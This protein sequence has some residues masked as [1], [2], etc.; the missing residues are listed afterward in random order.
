MLVWFEFEE[1]W[2]FTACHCEI[3]V[4][5]WK[6][7]SFFREG[8]EI[9]WDAT[10]SVNFTSSLNE[11]VTGVMN[12]AGKFWQVFEGRALLRFITSLSFDGIN[13]IH[14]YKSNTKCWPPWC[15]CHQNKKK[16][17]DL[18]GQYAPMI[19]LMHRKLPKGSIPWIDNTNLIW[20]EVNVRGYGTPEGVKCL[21]LRANE[22]CKPMVV[23]CDWGTKMPTG[24]E[25]HVEYVYMF[26][27]RTVNM[28]VAL[29][30]GLWN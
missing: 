23:M 14:P 9:Y 12:R 4:E 13:D 20:L 26:A 18:H 24:A 1:L 28:A 2:L 17:R 15:W 19:Y 8:L 21:M 6:C 22:M 30:H 27:H 11:G 5:R 29:V 7:N 3:Q 16:K 10:R 25:L